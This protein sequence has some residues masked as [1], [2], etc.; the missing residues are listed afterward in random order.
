MKLVACL[1]ACVLTSAAAQDVPAYLVAE[2]SCAVLIKGLPVP[3]NEATTDAM[4]AFRFWTMIRNMILDELDSYLVT[5]HH[6]TVIE[7]PHA[8]AGRTTQH[9]A[10]AL[11]QRQCNR[12]VSLQYDV[13][14]DA[15]GPYFQFTALVLRPTNLAPSGQ[16]YTMG[17]LKDEYRRVY[18][19]ART[20]EVIERFKVRDFAST[21]F[22]DM[23]KA[24]ALSALRR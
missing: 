9:A 4:Q 6:V 1:A 22:E 15:K 7:I 23:E 13:D 8:E 2:K 20:M 10:T 16:A 21:V 19:F 24:G 12:I 18:R 5:G 11:A 14:Q 3:Q 17:Q